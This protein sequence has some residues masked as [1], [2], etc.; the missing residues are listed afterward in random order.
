MESTSAKNRTFPHNKLD[1]I[2][3]D[4]ENGTYMLIDIA[5]SGCEQEK[6]QE[7]SEI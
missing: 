2:I 5:I 4:G 1:I 7:D 3:H 6:R